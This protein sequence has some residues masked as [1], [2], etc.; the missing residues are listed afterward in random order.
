MASNIHL[1]GLNSTVNVAAKLLFLIQIWGF[2][3]GSLVKNLW[4]GKIPKPNKLMCHN[5]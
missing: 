2:P 1:A 3:G 5:Y 4:S